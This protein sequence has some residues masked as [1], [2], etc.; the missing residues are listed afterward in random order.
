MSNEHQQVRKRCY[1][2]SGGFPDWEAVLT[3]AAMTSVLAEILDCVWCVAN[4]LLSQASEE[5]GSM[6]THRCPEKLTTRGQL[7]TGS[8][9]SGRPVPMWRELGTQKSSEL[10]LFSDRGCA[11]PCYS[12]ASS[13]VLLRRTPL[14][15]THTGFRNRVDTLGFSSVTH[16]QAAPWSFLPPMSSLGQ[17]RWP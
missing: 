17:E 9:A 14:E 2:L 8:T 15:T 4:G 7:L 10:L 1:R 13:T 5:E 12:L 3:E 11:R 16:Q 6:G